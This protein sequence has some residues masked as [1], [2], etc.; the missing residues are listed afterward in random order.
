MAPNF[1]MLPIKITMAGILMPAIM[2]ASS[3]CGG[4]GATPATGPGGHLYIGVGD[5]GLGGD[6]FGNG[7]NTGTLLGAILRIDVSGAR[8]GEPYV[9]PASNPFSG[10]SGS[11]GRFS[12]TVY[13][14]PGVFH[15]IWGRT[16]RAIPWRFGWPLWAKTDG[17]QLT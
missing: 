5:G 3:A 8:A 13:A 11:R 9:I 1:S 16:Y 14:I 4:T 17:R 10:V 7:Q 12:P 2:I 6:P 15:S